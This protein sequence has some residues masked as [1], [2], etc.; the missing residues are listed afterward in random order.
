MIILDFGSGETCKNDLAYIRRMID[1]LAAVDTGRHY[2]IIKWQLFFHD[3]PYSN[4]LLARLEKES[5][6]YAYNYAAM[7]GYE[8]TAS[9]FDDEALDFLS[10]Y[11]VPF[12]K[13]ACRENLYGYARSI[14]EM[15]IIPVVSVP[16]DY[17]YDFPAFTYPL[18]CVPRYPASIADYASRFSIATL[19]RGI[20][21]HTTSFEL[22]ERIRPAVY[23]CHYKLADSTGPDAAEFARTP[24]ALR[25]IL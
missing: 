2:I 3:I 16:D 22:F 11:K 13:I 6:D 20:S 23:E 9:V 18:A 8:T 12:I 15:S 14:R 4:R 10:Q 24:E 19:K 1:D 7:R 5:F 25:R 21:D 17:E